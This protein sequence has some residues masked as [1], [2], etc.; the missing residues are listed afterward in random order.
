I[1]C[2]KNIP[3]FSGEKAFQYLEKQCSF[4]PRNPNSDGHLLC[5]NYLINFLEE[6]GAEVK[7]QE[8]SEKVRDEIYN[9]TNIIATYYPQRQTRIFIGAHW[10]TRPWADLDSLEENRHLP[11]PGANDAASGVAVLFH[12]AEIL[13][14]YEPPLF[15]IDLL[16]FDGEDAGTQ[17]TNNE[18]CLGSKHFVNNYKGREP[19][20]VIII[21]MIGDKDLNIEIEGYS[22]RNSPELLEKIWKIARARNIPNFSTKISNFIYDDHYPFLEKGFNAIDII[23]FDYPYWHTLQDT[24]DKCSAQSLQIIGNVLTE[25]IYKSNER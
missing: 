14:K 1:G 8:F 18:W 9:L 10:D 7:T 23:D 15:G 4:G 3:E 21:D 12:L 2:S 6:N 13:N 20:A 11:I 17:G 16:F 24:P 19:E 22:Y 5:K 25:F